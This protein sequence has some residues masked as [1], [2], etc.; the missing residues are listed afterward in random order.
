MA[1]VNTN[2]MRKLLFFIFLLALIVNSQAQVLQPAK[3]QYELSSNKFK[4]GD[5][6]DLVFKSVID[7]GWHLYS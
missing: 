2:S 4:V 5:E 7:A 3:W 1:R 6:I